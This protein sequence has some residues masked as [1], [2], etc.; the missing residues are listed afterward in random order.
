[1]ASA[2]TNG[3]GKGNG[4]ATDKRTKRDPVQVYCTAYIVLAGAMSC[5]LNALANGQ[6][7]DNGYKPFAYLLG[8]TVP[9]LVLLLGK[10]GGLLWKRNKRLPAVAIGLIATVVLALSVVHCSESI[11][12]LTGSPLPLAVAMAVGIDAGMIACEVAATIS[13]P[14]K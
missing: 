11:A 14:K 13:G 7:S 8:V 3:K 10:I 4:R 5:G 6:H 1:M 2:S 9:L 12:L